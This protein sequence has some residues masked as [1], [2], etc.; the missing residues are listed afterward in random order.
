LIAF[1]LPALI[2]MLNLTSI[3]IIWSGSPVD[4]GQMQ[5]GAMIACSSTPCRLF[6][7]FMVT[8]CS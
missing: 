2:V 8:P 4:A 1:L 5:V 3:A 6:A 7:V